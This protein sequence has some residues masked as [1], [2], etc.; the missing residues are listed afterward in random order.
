[1]FTED[2]ITDRSER[3]LAAELLREKIFRQ[4]GEE[5][6]YSV[7]VVIEQFTVEGELR[8]IDAWILVE[9]ANQK[10]IIIGRQGK[11]M[12]EMA[13]QARK[14]MEALFCGKV[15]LEEWVK[16][17]IGW[18]DNAAILKSLGYE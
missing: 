7:S 4:V 9:K 12:K 11:R 2:E 16:V 5:V 8:R 10:A 17:K 14:D 13:T 15:Y 6:P 18:A 1:L 3:F